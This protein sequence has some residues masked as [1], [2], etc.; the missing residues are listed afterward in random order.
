MAELG[1]IASGMGIV[2]F[3]IQISDSVLRLKI[4]FGSVKEAIEEIR[5]LIEEIQTLGLVLSELAADFALVTIPQLENAW[6]FVP[7]VQR[8]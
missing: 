4:F 6:S 5:Y 1:I 8:Y 7:G 2:S 3:A